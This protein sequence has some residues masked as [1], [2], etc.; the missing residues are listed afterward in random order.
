MYAHPSDMTELSKIILSY[1]LIVP[2]LLLLHGSLAEEGILLAAVGSSAV[3]GNISFIVPPE[4]ITDDIPF[5]IDINLKT[6]NIEG[7]G[8]KE[9]P[10]SLS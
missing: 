6:T 4:I 10:T 2:S 8:K 5:S 1:Y 7:C 9:L 3:V